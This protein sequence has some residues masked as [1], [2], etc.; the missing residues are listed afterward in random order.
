MVEERLA[1]LEV[2]Q[3][4]EQPLQEP[5]RKGVSLP[6]LSA[7]MK[8]SLVDFASS[9]APRRASTMHVQ[10]GLSGVLPCTDNPMHRE[11]EVP[12]LERQMSWGT[13]GDDNL[14]ATTYVAL[15]EPR[16][17]G[18][19]LPDLSA[20]ARKPSVMPDPD[21]LRYY[22][23]SAHATGP[24]YHTYSIC[25][26]IKIKKEG[27]LFREQQFWGDGSDNPET[28]QNNAMASQRMST[29]MSTPPSSA[30]APQPTR[31]AA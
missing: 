2:L 15:Q 10:T 21:L 4:Q 3:K 13:K 17:K 6:N 16:R 14:P 26:R 18:V 7:A 5:R 28:F 9:L 23:Y 22:G 19:S 20:A 24:A 12:A 8:K 27:R 30:N 11:Q 25:H 29:R 31:S 1:E